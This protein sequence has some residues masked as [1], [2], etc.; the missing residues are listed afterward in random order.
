MENYAKSHGIKKFRGI[1]MR[2]YLMDKSH[3]TSTECG[4]INLGDI[5][6][7]MAHIG[8][9][10]FMKKQNDKIYFD[11]FGNTCPPLELV[12]YLVKRELKYNTD[13]IQTFSDPWAFGCGGSQTF[14]ERR[15][16]G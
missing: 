6:I 15:R 1:F 8:W 11:S 10:C 7:Q 9:T 4:I 5:Y 13:K 12:R 14:I 2:D 16:V 3:N